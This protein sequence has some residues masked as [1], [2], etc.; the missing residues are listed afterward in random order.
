MRCSSPCSPRSRWRQPATTRTAQ[1]RSAGHTRGRAGCSAGALVLAVATALALHHA[2]H[3]PPPRSG[4]VRTSRPRREPGPALA[5]AR[6]RHDRSSPPPA[7]RRHGV[8]R[9]R[10]AATPGIADRGG[11][12]RELGCRPRSA[13]SGA[14]AGGGASHRHAEERGSDPAAQAVVGELRVFAEHDAPPA[15]RLPPALRAPGGRL[16]RPA[17]HTHTG[18][19]YVAPPRPPD[20]GD[21]ATSRPPGTGCLLLRRADAPPASPRAW[22]AR[23]APSGSEPAEPRASARPAADSPRC[24]PA[25]ARHL[26]PAADAPARPAPGA[27]RSSCVRSPDRPPGRAR[28]RRERA[29]LRR[30]ATVPVRRRTRP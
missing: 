19:T 6:A 17:D 7:R 8:G 30:R 5:V 1:R 4:R 26:S 28:R 11:G 16:G 23:P 25:Q 10:L 22:C 15:R 20:A 2:P 14:A 3:R 27:R 21:R 24:P 18:Q 12:A 29:G 9:P 13:V